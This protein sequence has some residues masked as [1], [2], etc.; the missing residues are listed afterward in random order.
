MKETNKTNDIAPLKYRNFSFYFLL[1]FPPSVLIITVLLLIIYNIEIKRSEEI[2]LVNE[3][4]ITTLISDTITDYFNVSISDL[5]HITTRNKIADL[6]SNDTS[7][8]LEEFSSE[9][10]SYCRLKPLCYNLRVMD[11]DGMEIIKVL[12]EGDNVRLVSSSELQNKKDRYY[13]KNAI[14]LGRGEVYV[15]PV[16]LNIEHGVIEDPRVPVGAYRHDSLR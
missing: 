6:F 9:I 15:S 2:S 10:L 12:R 1:I 14:K 11:A 7:V 8:D 4:H 13:F 5:I 16:D 3:Q